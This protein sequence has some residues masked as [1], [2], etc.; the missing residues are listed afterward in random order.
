MIYD[1]IKYNQTTS[2]TFSAPGNVGGPMRV[3]IIGSVA[4]LTNDT[5]QKTYVVL[6]PK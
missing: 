2:Q 5:T 6:I 4:A 1:Q 3:F